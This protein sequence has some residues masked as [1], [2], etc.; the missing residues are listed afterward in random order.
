MADRERDEMKR[1]QWVHGLPKKHRD[2]VLALEHASTAP[3]GA[4]VPEKRIVIESTLNTEHPK[5][6]PR[7]KK[8]VRTYCGLVLDRVEDGVHVYHFAKP[9]KWREENLKQ[10]HEDTETDG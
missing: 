5:D 1:R 2:Y 7:A 4:S 9:G 8:R 3:Q 10:A 6:H